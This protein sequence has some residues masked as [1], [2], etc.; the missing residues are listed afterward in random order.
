[1]PVSLLLESEYI[2]VYSPAGVG[3][4]DLQAKILESI[5]RCGNFSGYDSR[6]ALKLARL[7]RLGNRVLVKSSLKDD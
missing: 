4:L 1:M 6:L 7:L 5:T 3:K 2:V